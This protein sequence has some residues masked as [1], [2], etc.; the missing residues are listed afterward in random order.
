MRMPPSDSVKRPVTSPWIFPR[1]RKSGRSFLK[2]KRHHPAKQPQ[3]PAECDRGQTP[4]QI[5]KHDERDH[6]GNESA[7]QLHQAGADKI[8]NTFGVGHDARDE[9]AGLGR[10]EISD[11]QARDVFLHAL[12]HFS[13]GAL[14]GDA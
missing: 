10:I 13:D 3:G 6:R 9:D 5:K 2:R 7:N 14:R 4:V 12:A 1:S 11:R 8:S